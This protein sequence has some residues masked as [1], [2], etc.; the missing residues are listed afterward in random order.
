M[1]YFV[2]SLCTLGR[3]TLLIRLAII[4]KK[5]KKKKS[6]SS[7]F[8]TWKH[9]YNV[10]CLMFLKFMFYVSMHLLFLKLLPLRVSFSF[11][12]YCAHGACKLYKHT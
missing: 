4:I 12:F 7:G 8:F 11:N 10:L 1:I 5:K 6:L 9:I 3:H 2:Y